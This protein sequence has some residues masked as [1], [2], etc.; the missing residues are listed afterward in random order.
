MKKSTSGNNRVIPSSL[1]KRREA[2]ASFLTIRGEQAKGSLPGNG[3]GI[4]ALNP[5]GCCTYL[6]I[7]KI[8]SFGCVNVYSLYETVNIDKR[9][10]Y[11]QR[12]PHGAKRNA[13]NNK[14]AKYSRV[15]LR[16]L[17]LRKMFM[18]Q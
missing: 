13:G 10:V 9:L 12:S 7:I 16:L 5:L 18:A 1:P 4:N 2:C 17:Q 14:A 8:V 6:P 15:P 11:S 3:S